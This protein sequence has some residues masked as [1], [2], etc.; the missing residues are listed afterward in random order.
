[1]RKSEAF[2]S[3]AIGWKHSQKIISEI[4]MKGKEAGPC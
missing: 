4:V 3:G 1:M 2:Y